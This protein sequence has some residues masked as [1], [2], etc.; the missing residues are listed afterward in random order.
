M[1]IMYN[2]CFMLFMSLC[3]HE[4]YVEYGDQCEGAGTEHVRCSVYKTYMIDQYTTTVLPSLV[5][6]SPIAHNN[7]AQGESLGT[8]LTTPWNKASYS[9]E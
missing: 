7:Y 4:Q 2:V 3:V 8:R 1:Y 6:R 9:L 5:P